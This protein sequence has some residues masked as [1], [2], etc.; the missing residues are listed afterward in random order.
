V[1]PSIRHILRKS[2]ERTTELE[3]RTEE[4]WRQVNESAARARRATDQAESAA[5]RLIR[6]HDA[7]LRAGLR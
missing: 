1:A 3:Q 7:L 5:V 4:R 6:D 2:R